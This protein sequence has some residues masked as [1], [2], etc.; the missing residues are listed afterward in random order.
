M[1]AVKQN[2]AGVTESL[3]G[4]VNISHAIVQVLLEGPL[5]QHGSPI[6][7]QQALGVLHQLQMLQNF[8]DG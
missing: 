8:L 4:R 5:G 7:H 3:I 6:L 1:Q 2:Q